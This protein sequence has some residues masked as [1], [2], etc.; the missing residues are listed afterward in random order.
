MGSVSPPFEAHLAKYPTLLL[1][2]ALVFHAAQIVNMPEERARDIAAW[3]VPVETMQQAIV[4]MRRAAQHASPVYLGMKGGSEAFE[5]GR[6][7]G[8]AIIAHGGSQL[9]RR[10]LIQRVRAFRSATPEVQ[11]AALAVLVDAGW[12]RHCEGGYAKAQPVR[13]EVNPLLAVRMAEEAKQ[14]RHVVPQSE[15]LSPMQRPSDAP[16]VRLLSLL[17]ARAIQSVRQGT[18]FY[19]FYALH[20]QATLSTRAG[21]SLSV[22]CGRLA[23]LSAIA[24]IAPPI[25]PAE[26]ERMKRLQRRTIG[27][28]LD[29][30]VLAELHRP[31]DD[32]SLAAE[33]R[34]LHATG[35]T[36]RD[37]ATALR[38]DLANVLEWLRV[39]Q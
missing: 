25:A 10:D 35:L 38:V 21:V 39:A 32:A 11:N 4:F 5:L 19:L 9:A 33:C 12:I 37:V 22:A 16:M 15:N 27:G 36:P 20:A 8:R 3:R 13:F 31:R 28:A 6:D 17:L 34:R 18:P 14:E 23:S 1:R 7:I 30:R 2:V 29:Y 24:P 26:V